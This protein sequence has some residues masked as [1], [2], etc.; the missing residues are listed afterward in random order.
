DFRKAFFFGGPNMRGNLSIG[1]SLKSVSLLIATGLLVL[2][3]AKERD[4]EHVI[5]NAF[6]VRKSDLAG[7]YAY[8]KTL[9]RVAYPGKNFGGLPAGYY[10]DNDKLVQ[11]VIR[12]NSLDVVSVDP[13]F[14]DAKD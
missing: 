2:G 13:L 1:V 12:E 11:F 8:L 7:T 3:C 5:P 9:T 4:V 14:Q 6:R 10:L